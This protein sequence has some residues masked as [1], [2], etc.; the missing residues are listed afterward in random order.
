MI[1]FLSGSSHKTN[2]KHLHGDIMSKDSVK[3]SDSQSKDSDKTTRRRRRAERNKMRTIKHIHKLLDSFQ[4]GVLSGFSNDS[5]VELAGTY[6]QLSPFLATN[7]YEALGYVWR[8]AWTQNPDQDSVEQLIGAIKD[9]VE[10]KT[11]PTIG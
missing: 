10:G 6:R 2:P 1:F 11:Q 4:E 5:W 8:T 7:E 3:N 9:R